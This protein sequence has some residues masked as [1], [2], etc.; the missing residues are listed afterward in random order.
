MNYALNQ[1]K[2]V[3]INLIKTKDETNWELAEFQIDFPPFINKG[4]NFI[5]FVKDKNGNNIRLISLSEKLKKNIYTFIYLFNQDGIYNQIRFKTLKNDLENSTI[6][7]S[8]NK[9]ID[10]QF[11]KN[12]SSSKIVI[13]LPWWK[14]IEETKDLI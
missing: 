13:Y 4:F 7:V 8:F 2:Y 3:L 14:N 1:I 12:I 6:E 9:D 11:Q 10:D 5:Q